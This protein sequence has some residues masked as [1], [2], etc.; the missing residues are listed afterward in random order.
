MGTFLDAWNGIKIKI[1][2]E[3]AVMFIIR[4]ES[5]S[6]EPNRAPSWMSIVQILI[7]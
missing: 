1:K 2:T 3:R 7:F 6:L 5:R 4:K